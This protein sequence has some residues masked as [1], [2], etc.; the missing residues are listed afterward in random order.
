M[1]PKQNV[2]IIICIVVVISITAVAVATTLFRQQSNNGIKNETFAATGD[3]NTNALTI[4]S[5]ADGSVKGGSLYAISPNPFTGQGNYTIRDGDISDKNPT[6]GIILING[7]TQ[8]NYTV[9]QLEAPTGFVRDKISKIIDINST[10]NSAT[11]TFSS[12]PADVSNIQS[13]AKVQSIVYTAKFECGTIN[14][15]EGPIRPGHYDTD[16]GVF[17]K[18]EFPVKITWLAS[19]N[20]GKST[21]AILRTLQPQTS[22]SIVCKDL[23]PAFGNKS[24][25]EGFALIQVPLDPTTIAAVSGSGTTVIGRT[26]DSD[27][28]MLDVQVFYTA[29]ALDQLPH[30]ILVDKI[31][32]VITNDTSGKI[33]SSMQGKVLDI[34]MPSEMSK[35][36]DTETKVKQAI[37]KQ[38]DLTDRD[39][40]GLQIVIKGVDIGV[41]TMIDD[42]AVSLSRLMPQTSSKDID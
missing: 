39:L 35:I 19:S 6:E 17:N 38:Y 34:T 11:A 7:I 32:F 3:S 26:S 25:V 13:N 20:E 33:S 21:V 8:G 5:V 9:T 40:A 24:F 12:T 36:T 1:S 18:Q 31:S 23:Q 27:I 16:I 30:S 2:A 42:H 10:N 22:T 4:V 28:N 41:G 37:A 29:N 15:N 14:G